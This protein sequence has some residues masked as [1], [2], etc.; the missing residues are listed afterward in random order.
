MLKRSDA[1]SEQFQN[2]RPIS[3]FKVVSKLVEKAV[4]MQLTD[5][6]MSPYL[7]EVFQSAYKNFY[8]METALM[9]VQSDALRA[10]DKNDSILLLLLDLSAE[11][12]TLSRPLDIA[13]KTERSF[14]R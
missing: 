10:M 11:F 1:D 14:W 12:D 6:V 4:A 2:F 7:D 3:N 8:S 9:K 5:H 13:I